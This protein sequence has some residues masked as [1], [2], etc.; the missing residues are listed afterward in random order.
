MRKPV[1]DFDRPHAAMVDLPDAEETSAV[2]CVLPS[3][4][5]PDAKEPVERRLCGG[6]IGIRL[7]DVDACAGTAR[8][9]AARHFIRP[10][11]VPGI[12]GQVHGRI[13]LFGTR[14]HIDSNVLRASSG[15][16]VGVSMFQVIN[17][18][19]VVLANH[20]TSS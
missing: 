9:V 5:V 16:I 18:V 17:H 15:V 11:D 7:I 19:G 3:W 14:A 2:R 12:I 8:V 13:A 20:T 4:N 6:A 1:S 10:F